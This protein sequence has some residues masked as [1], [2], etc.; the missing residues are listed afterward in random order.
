MPLP[1][2][3]HLDTDTV[4][5]EKP[6]LVLSFPTPHLAPHEASPMSIAVSASAT[7]YSVRVQSKLESV[8]DKLEKA[9]NGE[10]VLELTRDLGLYMRWIVKTLS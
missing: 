6:S 1:V 7:G 5:T 2:F 3:I 10:R 4:P 9:G 8:R